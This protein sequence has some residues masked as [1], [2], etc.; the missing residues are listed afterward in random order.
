MQSMSALDAAFLHVEDDVSHMHIGATLVGQ[1]PAPSHEDFLGRIAGKLQFVPRYRQKVRFAPLALGWPVW[2]DDP[3]FNLEYHVRRTALPAPG[4]EAEL[5]NLIGR[6]MS[7]QLD[8]GKPLWEIWF[9]EGLEDDRWA[10]ITKVHHCMVDGVSAAEL[11]GLLLDVEPDPAALELPAWTPPAEPSEA[12]LLRHVLREQI[13]VPGEGVRRLREAI[14]KP[15]SS[16][17]AMLGGA[18]AAAAAVPVLRRTQETSLNGPIGPHRKYAW[19]RGRL[20]D[21]KTIRVAFG[22]TVNDVIL[23]VVTRGFRDLLLARGEDVEGMTIR[24][25]V[26]VSVR[27]ADA[28]GTPDNRVSAMWAELPVGLVD[29]VAR[30]RSVSLQMDG[31]KESGQAVGGEVLTSLG[32]FAPP[33]LLALGG[34]LATRVPHRNMNTVTTN[35]PGPQYPLY[36]VGRRVLEMYPYMPLANT[37][38][39]GV[40]IFS[41]DGGIYVG[42]TGDADTAPDIDVLCAGVEAGLAELLELAGSPGQGPGLL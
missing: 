14:R 11:L 1:G 15:L 23:T 34:R 42:V 5:R 4:A 8:R 19:A 24:S 38:R 18:R 2:V 17:G 25:M 26:P 36:C 16:A 35:I 30:L 27:T 10:I 12:A 7:Q 22:G 41:Y 32:A 33:V 29:P 13:A 40:S 21:V 28:Q 3:H 39:T 37:V 9:V 6:L 31:L 20:T